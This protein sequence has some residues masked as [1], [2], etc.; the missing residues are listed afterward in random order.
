MFSKLENRLGSFRRTTSTLQRD[1]SNAS[2]AS[3][4]YEPSAA[5]S[6]VSK[7]NRAKR[8]EEMLSKLPEEYLQD[9]FDPVLFEL[10]QLPTSFDEQ[11]LDTI[12]DSRASVLEVCSS[13]ATAQAICFVGLVQMITCVRHMQVVGEKLSLHVLANY[14]EFVRGVNEVAS[15]EQDL[16][17]PTSELTDYHQSAPTLT[18]VNSDCPTVDPNVS[19][20]LQR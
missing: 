11:M 8:R 13:N 3:T 12:V 14:E 1:A 4:N 5:P 15:I 19:R 9:H 18:I 7:R 20:P 10:Q 6:P 17:V 16:Q 2:I